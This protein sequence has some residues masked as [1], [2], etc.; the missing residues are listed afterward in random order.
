MCQF[1]IQ[2]EHY[3]S[4]NNSNQY[5]AS[6]S[7]YTP[8]AIASIFRVLGWILV[9]V[10]F[11]SGLGIFNFFSQIGNSGLGFL[12]F[13]GSISIFGFQALILF[14]FGEIIQSLHEI[15]VNTRSSRTTDAKVLLD[16]LPK[17]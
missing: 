5:K 2:G 4:Q 8:N 12:G 6:N 13:I 1:V 16:E 7:G 11:I 14:S 17:I 10:G 9:V 15:S 3:M